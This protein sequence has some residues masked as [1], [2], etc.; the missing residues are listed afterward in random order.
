LTLKNNMKKN[1]TPNTSWDFYL[2]Q[3]NTYAW[4]AEVFSKEECEKII[5]IAKDTGMEEA[6]THDG[7]KDIR[8][9]DVSWLMPSEN[10]DWAYRKITDTVL[11]LNERYFKFDISGFN[12]GFQFTNYKAPSGNYGKH[13]DRA[14]NF[15]IRKLSLSV[16]LSDPKDYEGGDLRLYESN[17]AKVM[18]KEQGTL[19]LFP[20]FILHEVM[21]VTKGERNSLVAWV[22]GKQFK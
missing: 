20:S 6:T 15:V 18:Q 8:K 22:T 2:D 10:L 12:E 5:K 3:V 1:N 14:N 13:V 11:H 16:Q 9:S 21:P 17:K 7:K 19:I 4:R